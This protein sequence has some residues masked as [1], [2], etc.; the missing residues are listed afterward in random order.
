MYPLGFAVRFTVCCH[1]LNSL[2]VVRP[3]KG[4]EGVKCG[5]EDGKQMKGLQELGGGEGGG[6]V[7]MRE[8]GE[9]FNQCL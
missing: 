9:K 6:K 8:D 5:M 7:Y 1:P 4:G 3:Q 2:P